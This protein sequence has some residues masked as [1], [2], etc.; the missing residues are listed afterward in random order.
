VLLD[1]EREGGE[2]G[3]KEKGRGG[4]E[5]PVGGGEEGGVRGVRL[6][7]IAVGASRKIKRHR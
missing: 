3:K 1:R 6:L 4:G 2:R 7:F 5:V